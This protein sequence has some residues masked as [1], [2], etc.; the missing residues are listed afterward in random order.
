MH[1]T[2]S[3]I[4]TSSESQKILEKPNGLTGL[5]NLG[6]TCYL[7]SALQVL[8][9]I[10]PLTR[11]LM[12]QKNKNVISD[13]LLK[14]AP[15]ILADNILFNITTKNTVVPITLREKIHSSQYNYEDLSND[16]KNIII[17]NTFTGQLTILFEVMWKKNCVIMPSSFKSIFSEFRGKTFYGF[18]QHDSPEAFVCIV[19]KIQEE[20]MYTKNSHVIN[21]KP[22]VKNAYDFLKNINEKI[23]TTQDINEKNKFKIHR[24]AFLETNKKEIL[25]IESYRNIQKY[26][27]NSSGIIAD[28]F[29]GFTIESRSCPNST[30]GY[31]SN[32]FDVFLMLNLSIPNINNRVIDLHDC[33]KE[34]TKDEIMDE[35]N[36]WEC[37]N[38][39]NY[40][41]ASFKTKI[42]QSPPILVIVLKRF[43]NNT[44]KDNRLINFE[45]TNFD[46]SD[47]VSSENIDSPIDTKYK[48][49]SIIN[50]TGSINNGHYYTYCVDEDT[51]KWYKYDDMYVSSIQNTNELITSS[52]Y[53]LT[54]IRNDL[55]KTRDNQ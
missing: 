45:I 1:Y 5:V 27:L 4:D 38:C 49:I 19:Q 32:R 35:K 28:I 17:G 50:H 47:Y 9:H 25:M 2:N 24:Q 48:L 51:D 34:Y 44:R 31:V 8:G 53:M 46:V 21:C 3:T 20:L 16:E 43:C 29:S 22:E 33:M 18:A 36:K 23:L 41:C 10:N 40:V 14:N 7:N 13:I 15:K 39:K 54:Y 55:I 12:N 37:S 6:N 42:W 30:C 26:F 11:Y 52:A